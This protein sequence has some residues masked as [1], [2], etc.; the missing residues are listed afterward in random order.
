MISAAHFRIADARSAIATCSDFLGAVQSDKPL[1]KARQQTDV[2]PLGEVEL[3]DAVSRPAQLRLCQWVPGDTHY[4]ALNDSCV[5]S[6]LR[7]AVTTRAI[8]AEATDG[9]GC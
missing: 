4:A 3:R 7:K 2:A 6:F 1:F 5:L 9:F 8:G